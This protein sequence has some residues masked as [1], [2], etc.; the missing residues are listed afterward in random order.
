MDVLEEFIKQ[1]YIKLK[2]GGSIIIW[3]DIWKITPL[4]TLLEKY[5]FKS[6]RF[7]EWIKTNPQPLNS[8]HSYLTNCREMGLFAVKKSKPTFNSKYDNA[9]YIVIHYKEVSIDFIQPKKVLICLRIL[10]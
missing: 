9:M 6:I 8:S 7:I 2:D 4:K 1:Y 5:G 10:F 3:F